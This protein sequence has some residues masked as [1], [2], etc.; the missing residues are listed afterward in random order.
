MTPDRILR[1]GS[2]QDWRSRLAGGALSAF[3]HLAILLALF[4]TVQQIVPAIS[5]A[6]LSV[7]LLPD[8][9][10]APPAPPSIKPRLTIP[11][12]VTAAV[13]AFSVDPD[14]VVALAPSG[15]PASA[16]AEASA[17]PAS[18][19]PDGNALAVYLA[20]IS[21]YMQIRLRKP[22]VALRL[23]ETGVAT[24]HLV[25][26]RA[27]HVLLVELLKS[28]GHRDLDDEA[29][30]VVKRSDPLP[31]IPPEIKA[32]VINAQMPVNFALRGR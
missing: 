32:D 14:P 28:S 2:V 10:P 29:I 13:P 31:P 9:A 3:A 5:Q 20:R 30:A 26:N 12:P 4:L 8:K 21:A 7:L 6:P 23:G 15:P 16:P 22:L 11:S 19:A 1:A 27:G 18:G 25:F 24:V 17:A